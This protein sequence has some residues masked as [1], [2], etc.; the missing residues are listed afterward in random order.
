MD[1]SNL[2]IASID[3]GHHGGPPPEPLDSDVAALARDLQR[4]AAASDMHAARQALQAFVERSLA[5]RFP[6]PPL[7]TR[8]SIHAL[9]QQLYGSCGFAACTA[10]VLL[11]ALL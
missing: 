9:V 8:T 6:N 11:H 10:L 7:L 3:I 2:V 5:L 1:A 4:C